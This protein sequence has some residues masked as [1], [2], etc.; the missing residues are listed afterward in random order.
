VKDISE[1]LAPIFTEISR[2]RKRQ[3]EKWGKQNH[4]MLR[5]VLKEDIKSSL[6]Y[7]RTI[8]DKSTRYD[9][10]SILQEE[11]SEVF[12]ETEQEKQREEMIQVAAVAVRIIE[13][14]DRCKEAG[15]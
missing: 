9:W 8:N 5:C 7:F 2:E 4:E 13:Y 6:E 14:L 15:K 11:I 10:Y 12:I 1:K 3:D